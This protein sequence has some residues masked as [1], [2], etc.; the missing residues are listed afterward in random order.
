MSSHLSTVAKSLGTSL[1]KF[2][3][4]A[5]DHELQYLPDYSEVAH[6]LETDGKSLASLEFMRNFIRIKLGQKFV[7]ARA[8]K[9][10]RLK[11]LKCVAKSGKLNDLK[12]ELDPGKR[13]RDLFAK[14][15]KLDLGILPTKLKELS[16]QDLTGLDEAIGFKAPRTGSGSVSKSRQSINHIVSQIQQIKLSEHY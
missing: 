6:L 3:A 16:S 2:L 15:V 4:Q 8:D 13:Y 11:F 5:E 12:K 1:N 14:I 9:A 7:A 10:T